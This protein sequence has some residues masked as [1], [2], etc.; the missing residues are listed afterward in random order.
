MFPTLHLFQPLKTAPHF[1]LPAAPT[2]PQLEAKDLSQ[3]FFFFWVGGSRSLPSPFHPQNPPFIHTPHPKFLPPLR[4]RFPIPNPNLGAR[5]GSPIFNFFFFFGGGGSPFFPPPPN[6]RRFPALPPRPPTHLGGSAGR[7]GPGGF[8]RDPGVAPGVP[9]DSGVRGGR[10]G[11]VPRARFGRGAG[12]RKVPSSHS[13]PD[14]P[15]G[16]KRGKKKR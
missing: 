12:N 5:R 3:I 10:D 15:L 6:K 14:A 1:L 16:K 11:G 9:S 7:E 4:H 2:H 8:R 13:P